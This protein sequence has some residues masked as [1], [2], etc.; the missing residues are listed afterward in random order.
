MSDG[1][2][3]LRPRPDDNQLTWPRVVLGLG[4]L[5]V[6]A[7]VLYLVYLRGGGGPVC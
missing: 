2:D 1:G 4:V 7:F 6:V 5:A 3:D